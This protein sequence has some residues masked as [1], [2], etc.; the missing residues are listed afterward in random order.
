MNVN[1]VFV[2]GYS[3][4]L[5]GSSSQFDFDSVI[6]QLKVFFDSVPKYNNLEVC[7]DYL[8]Y[9]LGGETLD[10]IFFEIAGLKHPIYTEMLR[11]IAH[12]TKGKKKGNYTDVVLDCA[13]YGEAWKNEFISFYGQGKVI[14]NI[15]VDL[16]VSDAPCLYSLNYKNLG[17]HP[18]SEM[19]FTKRAKLMYSNISYHRD[20]HLTLSTV[21]SGDFKLYA[22]EFAR[23]LEALH[24]AFPKLTNNGHYKPDLEIIKAESGISGRTMGCTVQGSNKLALKRDFDITTLDGDISKHK[25]L[26]CEYH[27]KLN[28]D[29]NGR[30]LNDGFYN[31]A[32]FGL[33]LINGTKYI[34][35][36][37]L[38]KHL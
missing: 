23:S 29:N 30:K 17:S 24:N 12:L 4:D 5:I 3:L 22:V 10:D 26:N 8:E 31:R 6:E 32:Y 20:F 33:P 11:E 34:A 9:D 7:Q 25:G 14:P 35:L 2:T 36:M 38:G 18:I 1:N 15:H 37:H 21:K 19:S 27:L 28:F 16:V 13:D